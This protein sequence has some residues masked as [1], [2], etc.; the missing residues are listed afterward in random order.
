MRTL[1]VEYAH[2]AHAHVADAFVRMS[3]VRPED[4]VTL[5]VHPRGERFDTM[6]QQLPNV[7]VLHGMSE[8]PGPALEALLRRERYDRVLLITVERHFADYARAAWDCPVDLLIHNVDAWFEH[9][10]SNGLSWMLAQ[11]PVQRW[12]RPET[13]F[14]FKHAFV[15]PLQ[16]P[17][18]L[19]RVAESGGRYVVSNARIADRLLA[20]R[21]LARVVVVPFAAHLAALEGSPRP[22][23][24]L[25][26][27]VPGSI[28]ASRRD[29]AELW[30]A[31]DRL[32]A[33]PDQWSVHLLGKPVWTDGA[34]AVLAEVAARA[35]R[36][37]AVTASTGELS[38][39]AFDAGLAAADLLLGNLHVKIKGGASY[40]DTTESGVLHMALRSGRPLL[41][42]DAYPSVELDGFVRRYRGAEGLAVALDTL[43]AD[44][45]HWHAWR[46]QCRQLAQA[47][48]P[49]ALRQRLD[50]ED[51]LP[52]VAA[53][54]A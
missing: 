46:E 32:K 14:F 53:T 28:S 38:N 49:S 26:V 13:A 30:Q 22:A 52:K 12:W 37:Q 20:L 25:R 11:W 1:V 29:Y 4:A 27:V 47:Y 48:T 9:R 44:A 17:A 19:R 3:A 7:Q 36:G 33:R 18:L 2:P 54:S 6:R 24:P 51:Q 10:A 21:P 40:G 5:L 31:L 34:E 42:T 43:L 16:R 45:S 41:L 8:R 15:Y 23:G 50:G 35:A 39:E